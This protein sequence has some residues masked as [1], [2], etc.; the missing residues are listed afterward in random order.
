MMLFGKVAY[1]YLS[2]ADMSI[3][4]MNACTGSSLSL[5]M[6]GLF[7]AEVVFPIFRC[8]TFFVWDYVLDMLWETVVVL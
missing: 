8:S 5:T 4:S 6:V 3:T 1:D 7:T 2:D